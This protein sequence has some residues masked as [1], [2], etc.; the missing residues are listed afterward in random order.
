MDNDNDNDNDSFKHEYDVLCHN[1]IRRL[2]TYQKYKDFIDNLENGVKQKQ[3]R[4]RLKDALVAISKAKN[5]DDLIDEYTLEDLQEGKLKPFFDNT[6]DEY[7]IINK[8][9]W[10]IWDEHYIRTGFKVSDQD[11]IAEIAK[12]Y[13][14]FTIR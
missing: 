4:K 8:F 14:A 2:Q 11:I 13:G 10:G 12:G 9:G 3:Y 1:Q 6:N 7:E 5:G